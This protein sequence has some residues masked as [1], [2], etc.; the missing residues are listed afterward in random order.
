MKTLKNIGT[1]CLSG[2]ELSHYQAL[3]QLLV[4]NQLDKLC[5]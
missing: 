4:V 2:D 3:G 1:A 5:M